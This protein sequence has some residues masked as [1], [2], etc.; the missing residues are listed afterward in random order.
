MAKGL[1]RFGAALFR[2]SKKLPERPVLRYGL[3]PPQGA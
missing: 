2:L 1:P 3:Q